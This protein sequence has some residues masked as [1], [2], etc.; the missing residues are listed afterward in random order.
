MGGCPH[1]GRDVLN[2]WRSPSRQ[3]VPILEG[4]VPKLR[5]SSDW[6]KEVPPT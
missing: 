2:L 3:G 4:R 6:G 1:P 5:G